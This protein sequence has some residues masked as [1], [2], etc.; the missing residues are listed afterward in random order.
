MTY[1]ETVT[2]RQ[3]IINEHYVYITLYCTIPVSL[4]YSEEMTKFSLSNFFLSLSFIVNE[5]V[6]KTRIFLFMRST[7]IIYITFS[8]IRQINKVILSPGRSLMDEI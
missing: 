7:T 8:N 3:N 6:V 2:K 1:N 5:S 4:G